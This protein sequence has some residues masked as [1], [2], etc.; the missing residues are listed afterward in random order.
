M[1]TTQKKRS[2]LQS[3]RVFQRFMPYFRPYMGVMLLDLFCATLTTVC[4]LV[5]PLIVRFITSAVTS[6][7]AAL[8]ISVVL[9]LGAVYLLLRVIDTAAYYYMQSIGH[10]MGS[11]IESDLRRDL[12]SHYQELSNDFYDNTKIGQLMSRIT[13]DLNDI[14][15]FAHHMPEELLIVVLK[16][17][18]AFVI[19]CGSNVLLTVIIFAVLPLMVYFSNK[20]AKKMRASFKASRHELGELNSQ[21]ED[22][23]SGIRV[24]K[25]FAN[26]ELEKEKFAERNSIFL[27]IKKDMYHNMAG[28]HSVTRLFDGVMYIL[29]V[30]LGAVFMIHGKISAPDF[31]AYLLYVQTLLT[32]I[33]RFVEFTEQLQRG[34]TS[35]ERFDEVMHEPV[36]IQE[37]PDALELDGVRG[38]IEFDDVSFAYESTREQVLTNISLTVRPGE[39]VAL[40]GPSGSGK[41]TLCSLIP[42]FYDVT[43]GA[44]RIDGH[45]VRDF[46]LKSLRSHIGVVQQDVYMF[47]GTIAEN[48]EYGRPGASREDVI[49]A[50]KLAGAHEFISELENGYDTY[51]GEHGLKLSGGQKQRIS[52][53]RV[54][55]KNPPILILDEATSALDN[56]SERLVQQSLEK[57]M[58]GRTTFTIAHR[59][60]TIRSADKILVLTDEGIVEQGS[61]AELMAREDGVYHRLYQLY[62]A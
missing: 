52:I 1:E 20:F 17:A 53:A 8:T 54:F 40:V 55:L 22:S 49:E 29:V 32:S 23:L 12:F 28:F 62:T 24:V 35:F 6:D 19:L 14:T 38:E 30:V 37:K 5:L 60:T 51:V 4:D 41:T 34:M 33:R 25:S 39:S 2:P 7:A 10:V 16:V 43:S 42:R 57:L 26:E 48:I 47:S 36:T 18:V 44:I 58:R 46:T 61:H 56:E 3:L 9:R 13:T 27:K 31:V 15:E 50:A 21:V 45:D 59:L 11:H